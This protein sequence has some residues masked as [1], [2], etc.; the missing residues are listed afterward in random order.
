MYTAAS[1]VHAPIKLLASVGRSPPTSLTKY[2]DGRHMYIHSS[3]LCVCT[4]Q[5]AHISWSKSPYLSHKTSWRK[6]YLSH[7]NLDGRHMY[8]YSSI[9]CACT[10]ENCSHQLAEVHIRLSQN[11]A[12]LKQPEYIRKVQS[13]PY[14]NLPTEHFTWKELVWRGHYYHYYW[15]WRRQNKLC[16]CFVG[17]IKTHRTSSVS[18][19]CVSYQNTQN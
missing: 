4:H 9:L 10:H 16:V 7:K 18:A 8:V 15:A 14:H 12:V 19:L 6:A 5:I 3:N 11:K 17:L 1:C 13:R 2:L